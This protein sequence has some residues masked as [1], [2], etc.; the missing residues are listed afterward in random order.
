M[1]ETEE[2][3]DYHRLHVAFVIVSAELVRLLRDNYS[4]GL[5]IFTDMHTVASR[6][7]YSVL[8]CI[9]LRS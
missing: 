2:R 3:P 7:K 8:F 1:R 9:S 4:G 5:V 6:K